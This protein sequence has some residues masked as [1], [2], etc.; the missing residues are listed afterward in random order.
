MKAS[1]Q[2]THQAL[3]Q[4]EGVCQVLPLLVADDEAQPVEERHWDGCIVQLEELGS[5]CWVGCP[6]AQQEDS[7]HLVKDLAAERL[8]LK[9]QMPVIGNPEHGRCCSM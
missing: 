9:A 5:H 6:Q 8:S 3:L 4:P 1:I 2:V 7:L